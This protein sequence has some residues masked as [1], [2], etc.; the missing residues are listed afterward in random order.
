M[1]H[2]LT[3]DDDRANDYARYT[4]AAGIDERDEREKRAAFTPVLCCFVFL[5]VAVIATAII[6]P[7]VALN[8]RAASP[9]PTPSPTPMPTQDA[10][11]VVSSAATHVVAAA[12]IELEFVCNQHFANGTCRAFFSY[13]NRSPAPLI[14]ERGINNA[15]VPGAANRGQ[16]THF[17]VG[18]HFA[19]DT[20]DWNCASH[21][22]IE[23]VVLTATARATRVAVAC[24]SLRALAK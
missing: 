12:P 3:T 17:D 23:R 9:S 21:A 5:V 2:R 14:V 7:T 10:G 13:T 6:V 11:S 15:A 18:T 16:R 1:A 22:S 8:N 19:A 20:I 4:R 24:P